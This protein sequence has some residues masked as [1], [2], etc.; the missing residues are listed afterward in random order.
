MDLFKARI[1]RGGIFKQLKFLISTPQRSQRTLLLSEIGSVTQEI[2][3]MS[4]GYISADIAKKAWMVLHNLKFRVYKNGLPY[5]DDQVLLISERSYIPLDPFGEIKP[6]DKERMTSL[7]D[8]ARLRHA[9]AR[10]DAGK[11][12]EGSDVASK[13]ITGC[14]IM[15]GL[16]LMVG[17]LMHSCGGGA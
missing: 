1:F 9:D 10:A 7:K 15:L 3:P 16:I 4:T 11:Q 6:K 2:L 8:I 12:G 13:V 14:F 17:L 5:E